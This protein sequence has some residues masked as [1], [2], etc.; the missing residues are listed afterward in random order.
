MAGFRFRVQ[1][2][3]LQWKVLLQL[4]DENLFNRT[5]LESHGAFVNLLAL[6]LNVD[7]LLTL[8]VPFGGGKKKGLPSPIAPILGNS[9]CSLFLILVNFLITV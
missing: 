1:N 4:C 3:K 7:R 2:F 9:F 5:T 6:G 8:Q